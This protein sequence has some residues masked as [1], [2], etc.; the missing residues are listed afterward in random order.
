M[1]GVGSV[2]FS[3]WGLKH[4]RRFLF[5]LGGGSG[6]WCVGASP[7]PKL[8]ARN[9]QKPETLQRHKRPDCYALNHTSLNRPF[10]AAEP[11]AGAV[12][13]ALAG[14]PDS[15]ANASATIHLRALLGTSPAFRAELFR[16]FCRLPERGNFE[17]R[18]F[19]KVRIYRSI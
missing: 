10:A 3:C 13:G 11:M 12:A 18:G 19:W 2:G 17:G 8:K 16:A 14:R 1:L 4:S 7:A 5:G 15:G 9:L 6:F